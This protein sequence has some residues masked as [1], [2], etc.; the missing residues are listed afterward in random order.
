ML[1]TVRPEIN[2]LH[3]CDFAAPQLTA[4][5]FERDIRLAVARPD[6]ERD[7][8]QKLLAVK[9]QMIW[10]ATPAPLQLLFHRLPRSLAPKTALLLVDNLLQLLRPYAAVL[11]EE[12]RAMGRSSYRRL[13]MM[14]MHILRLLSPTRSLVDERDALRSAHSHTV[15]ELEELKARRQSWEHGE[16]AQQS[17]FFPVV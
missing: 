3:W 1:Q 15:A 17:L 4:E 10:R 7:V 12:S 13:G 16:G 14:L 5:E 9:D 8:L 11:P 2:A 6:K